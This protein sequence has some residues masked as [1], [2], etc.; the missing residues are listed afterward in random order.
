MM[1][2]PSNSLAQAAPTPHKHNAATCYYIP[3][4]SFKVQYWSPYGAGLRQR[5]SLT[6]WIED[7]A[8]KECRPVQRR[9]G[10]LHRRGHPD[11][12][13]HRVQAAVDVWTVPQ[14]TLTT[15]QPWARL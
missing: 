12:V 11:D 4:I 7:R 1:K 6:L 8:L 14:V 10:S 3:T 2:C 5:R 13:A 15:L 9:A